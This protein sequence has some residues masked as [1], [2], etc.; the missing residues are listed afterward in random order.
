MPEL[1]GT[2]RVLDVDPDL[3]ARIADSEAGA[4]ADAAFAAAVRLERGPWT[5]MPRRVDPGALGFLVLD[6]LLTCTVR[7]AGRANVELVGR[8]DVLRPWMSNEGTVPQEIRWNV[9][10]PAQ[11]AWLDRDFAVRTARWPE[12]AAALVERLVVRARHLLFQ[13]GASALPRVDE[14]LLLVLWDLA[15]RWGKVRVDG[16]QLPLPLSH[17]LLASIV[18][19][20]RP[21]VTTAL[22]RLRRDELVHQI[23]GG[24][25]LLGEPPRELAQAPADRASAA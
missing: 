25:L 14:R 6:G 9:L 20:Q 8:G 24:W 2:V 1:D 18:G 7:V 17:S 3:G 16:V 21:S 12:I 13:R 11:L 19:A 23:P 15:D 4:A 22:G 10:I 5:E